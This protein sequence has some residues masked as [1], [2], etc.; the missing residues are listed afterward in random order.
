M[1]E[2][3]LL[4]K[5][6]NYQATARMNSANLQYIQP[7]DM[8]LMQ[9]VDVLF[10]KSYMLGEFSNESK[11]SDNSVEEVSSSICH[12]LDSNRSAQPQVYLTDTHLEW[13]CFLPFKNIR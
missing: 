11:A 2:N 4:K 6:A 3:N 1:I 13:S 8:F 12:S 5:F 9:H 7:P 10:A